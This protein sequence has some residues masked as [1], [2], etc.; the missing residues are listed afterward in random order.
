MV[1]PTLFFDIADNGKT[2]GPIS[3]ESSKDRRKLSCSEHW[4]GK[5]WYKVSCFQFT[6]K[7]AGSGILPMAKAGP[8]TNGS[9]FF[10]CTAKTEWL[11]GKPV[12]CDR[13]NRGMNI[14]EAMERFGLRNDKTSKKI[15]TGDCGQI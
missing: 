1:N 6:L 12:V 5:I 14:V 13:V 8:N 7:H 4:E 10:I 2:L 3:F 11:D 9:Q 15:T